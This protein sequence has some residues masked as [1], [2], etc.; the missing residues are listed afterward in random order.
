MRYKSVVVY[1]ML[2]KSDDF[3]RSTLC[4]ARIMPSRDVCPSVTRR[5][6]FETAKHITELFSSTGSPTIT[7]F[8]VSKVVVIF[9]RRPRLGGR[10]RNIT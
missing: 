4:T 1:Q 9:Q 6:A 10:R 8:T 2:S 5:S 3:R 7:V